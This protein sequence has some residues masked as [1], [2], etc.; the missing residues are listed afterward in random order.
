MA[1]PLAAGAAAVVLTIAA[2][3]SA[4]ADGG[5]ASLPAQEIANKAHDALF[6]TS[7]LHISVHGRFGSRGTPTSMELTLDRQANCRGSVSLGGQGSVQIIKRG[8]KIWIKPDAAFW[9]NQVPGGDAARAALNG[10]YLEGSSSNLPLQGLAQVCDLNSF[11]KSSTQSG[12]SGGGHLTKGKVTK[13]HGIDVVPVSG[14]R[15]GHLETLYVA[16]HGKP[17]PV[18]V[19]VK[20]QDRTTLATVGFSGFDKPVPSSTP[21]PDQAVDISRLRTQVGPANST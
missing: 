16:T 5:T 12:T 6:G 19:A 1:K 10:R 15:G 11:L 7:S 20:A 14:V 18:Q 21:S 3:S 9:K 8:G 17:Y 2:G 4:V 13:L